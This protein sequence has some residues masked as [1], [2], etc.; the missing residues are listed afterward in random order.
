MLWLQRNTRRLLFDDFERG[1][2][3]LVGNLHVWLD[4]R[5]GPAEEPFR[6][7]D[8]QIDKAMTVGMAKIVVPERAVQ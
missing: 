2:D 8:T 5:F 7:R 3:G 1:A 4:D 6:G